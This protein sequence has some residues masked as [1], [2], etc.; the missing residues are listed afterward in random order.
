[1][2]I[3]IKPTIIWKRLKFKEAKRRDEV[4]RRI[5]SIIEIRKGIVRLPIF[6]KR[7]Q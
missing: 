7:F 1:L 4:S 3:N 2:V 5:E 6:R